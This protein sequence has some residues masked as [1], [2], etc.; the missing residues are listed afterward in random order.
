M[1][2]PKDI[3]VGDFC[4]GIHYINAASI[5]RTPIILYSAVSDAGIGIIQINCPS[6]KYPVIF[7]GTMSDYRVGIITVD[8]RKTGITLADC[9]IGQMAAVGRVAESYTSPV[10]ACCE[11]NGISC[12]SDR[13]Q[14][15]VYGKDIVPLEINNHTWLNSQ[16]GICLNG[17]I[18]LD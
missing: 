9:A 13:L 1:S 8:S 18:P 7:Y 14:K 17:D 15:A 16:S 3:A 5:N 12:R 10:C 11:V 6:E 2:I 4:S